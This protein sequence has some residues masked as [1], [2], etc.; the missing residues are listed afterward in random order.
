MKLGSK[1]SLS[2]KYS[3]V[4]SPV[5]PKIITLINLIWYLFSDV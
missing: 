4:L 3:E 1:L 5:V 2:L